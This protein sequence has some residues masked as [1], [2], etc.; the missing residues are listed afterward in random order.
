MPKT[1][2]EAFPKLRR[3]PHWLTSCQ[4]SWYN[5]VAWALGN[6][7]HW[8]EFQSDNPMR[9]WPC[10]APRGKDEDAYKGLFWSRG[11]SECADASLEPGFEKVAFYIHPDLGWRHVAWQREDGWWLSKLGKSWDIEHESLT[12][13]EGA[14]WWDY[15][16]ATTFMRRQRRP[17]RAALS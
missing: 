10:D 17:A 6:N 7:T 12:A 13:L 3:S 15:G 8:W 9:F 4:D 11:Y 1:L 16:F 5:C 2:D 14:G